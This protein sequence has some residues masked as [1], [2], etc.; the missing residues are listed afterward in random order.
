[1]KKRSPPPAR[2]TVRR[3]VGASDRKAAPAAASRK[4]IPLGSAGVARAPKGRRIPP[5]PAQLVGAV[6][7]RI[8]T[9]TTAPASYL[10]GDVV[11]LE[12]FRDWDEGKAQ[13]AAARPFLR[14]VHHLARSYVVRTIGGGGQR[15]TTE[16]ALSI[17]EE[18]IV[19]LRDGDEMAIDWVVARL[20]SIIDGSEANEAFGLKRGRGGR[21]GEPI[22]FKNRV[23]TLAIRLVAEGVSLAAGE[24]D[25]WNEAPSVR[26]AARAMAAHL[27]LEVADPLKWAGDQSRK[28]PARARANRRLG[29]A[30][31][32]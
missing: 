15:F 17:L 4:A 30:A 31:D 20:Q 3:A 6:K 32:S 2:P 1:M 9:E 27:R 29:R 16:E 21:G 8:L 14:Y 26:A 5:A 13:L 25:F 7:Q 28:R 11:R 12:F 23:N 18:R 24:G 10:L 22:S 19:A